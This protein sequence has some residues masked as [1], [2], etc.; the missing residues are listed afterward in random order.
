MFKLM[1][2]CYDKGRDAGRGENRESERNICD[3]ENR[4]IVIL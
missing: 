2:T 4:R 1:K 3:G